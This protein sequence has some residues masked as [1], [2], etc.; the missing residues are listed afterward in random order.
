[1]F[2]I[3]KAVA[4]ATGVAFAQPFT[5]PITK[6][7]VKV[8]D[9]VATKYTS[10][11]K[12]LVTLNFTMGNGHQTGKISW[13]NIMYRLPNDIA[14]NG[15]PAFTLQNFESASDG[16]GVGVPNFTAADLN[17]GEVVFANNV[18]YFGTATMGAVK[19]TA[20]QEAIETNGKGY[21][22]IHASGENNKTGWPWFTNT[23]HPM[24]FV[25]ENS[26]TAS[27]IYMNPEEKNHII[28]HGLYATKTVIIASAPDELDDAG[29]E[30]YATGVP[31]RTMLN[32]WIYW[33]RDISRDP[34]YAS[35][36]KILMKFDGTKT[37]GQLTAQYIRKGGNLF[38]HL[39]KVGNGMTSYLHSGHDPDE[40]TNA[41][42]TFDP[43]EPGTFTGIPW[44]C[45]TSWPGMT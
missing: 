24:N 13:R 27:P 31:G 30:K 41:N 5:T 43:R 8:N 32:E 23:L 33:G 29:N 6:T 25:G 10:K 28:L 9:G 37:G 7:F 39:Y 3:I 22:G 34:A 14:V 42:N 26:R 12:K 4:L 40:T 45:S 19:Q 18:S 16:A 36:V 11:L 38:A 21:F 44:P 17:S 1:M 15:V 20:I 2:K 35:K